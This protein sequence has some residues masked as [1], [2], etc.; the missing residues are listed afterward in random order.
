MVPTHKTATYSF[1]RSSFTDAE[2]QYCIIFMILSYV[3]RLYVC[4]NIGN[5]YEGDWEH[6]NINGTG[7]MVTHTHL[8]TLCIHTCTYFRSHFRCLLQTYADGGIY[9][10]TWLNDERDGTGTMKY[11]DGVTTYTGDW[12]NNKLNGKGIMIA[13]FGKYGKIT[14]HGVSSTS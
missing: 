10:G 3:G 1:S 13:N 2:G 4:V 8:H 7:T 6:S 5:K 11:A 14:T 12:K 9:T